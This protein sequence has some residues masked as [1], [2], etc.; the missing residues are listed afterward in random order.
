M[1]HKSFGLLLAIALLGGVLFFARHI[2]FPQAASIYDVEL[3]ETGFVPQT[4]AIAKGDTVVFT[5]AR[6]KPFWPASDLHPTHGIYPEFDPKEPI[7]PGESWSFRFNKVGEWR[8][9]DHLNSQYRGVI[10][11]REEEQLLTAGNAENP[12]N[13]SSDPSTQ[14][15]GYRIDS[16]LNNQGLD[17][18]F[19]VFAKAYLKD[20]GFASNCHGFTHKLGE[21]AYALFSK[22]QEV[23]LTP[24]TSYCGFGFYHGFLE[25][26]MAR[27]GSVRGAKEFC[28]YA[29]R[30]F[31][32]ENSDA[33]GAC[34]HG[35]GHGVVDGSDPGSWGDVEAF[36]APGLK[37][38]TQVADPDYFID[39]CASGVFNSLA[40]LYFDPKYK[41]ALN[42]DDPFWICRKQD[43]H[44]FK[45]PCYEEMNTLIFKLGQN[46]VLQSTRFVEEIKDDVYARLAMV[47][48]AAYAAF[49]IQDQDAAFSKSIDACR[50]IQKRLQTSCIVGFAAGLIEHGSPSNEGNAALQL[51]G[52]KKLLP[53]EQD[54]CFGR[55]IPYLAVVT[56]KEKMQEICQTIDVKYKKYCPSN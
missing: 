49:F 26:L 42:E 46:D 39:R 4:I 23:P 32:S 24:K 54:A 22:N 2:L 17:A 53:D 28:A 3:T 33:E 21:A 40:I 38:C 1:R 8:Y 56:G 47:S 30:A 7:E 44:Y 20:A 36:I 5:T 45:K 37:I 41:L 11:V 6:Q 51:C 43:A 19:D 52:S 34:F 15:W 50:R 31:A 27:T 13:S 9:H 18:A 25:A 14:C 29:K 55:V 12:C 35:I 10:T 48:L 16:A